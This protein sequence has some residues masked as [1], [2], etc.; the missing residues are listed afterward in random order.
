MFITNVPDIE[1]PETVGRVTIE[2]VLV[3]VAFVV[4]IL[5]VLMWLRKTFKPILDSIRNFLSDWNGEPER[6]GRDRR[7]GVMERLDILEGHAKETT[8]ELKPNS[9]H[10]LRDQID[11]TRSDVKKITEKV[12]SDED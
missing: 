11:F 1:I 9:G 2:Q 12:V 10:S 7:P 3:V 8:K 5:A 6:P 4:S